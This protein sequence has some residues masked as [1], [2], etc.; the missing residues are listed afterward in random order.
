MIEEKT[1]GLKS[2][3]TFPSR[4]KLL[5]FDRKIAEINYCLIEAF[6]KI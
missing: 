6:N 5:L 1:E 3:D 4:C 2:D